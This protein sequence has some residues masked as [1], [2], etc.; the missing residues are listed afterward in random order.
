MQRDGFG[1]A[2]LGELAAL[3]LLFFAAWM[4][5][6]YLTAPVRPDSVLALW[7]QMRA[8]LYLRTAVWTLHPLLAALL[9]LPALL[10]LALRRKQSA[11][12][13]GCLLALGCLA[14][15]LDGKEAL[16]LAGGLL[17]LG[18]TFAGAQARGQSW[19]IVLTTLSLLG[20]YLCFI[21]LI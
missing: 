9:A 5:G 19:Q 4:L 18:G 13:L 6:V 7:R 14:L 12:L 15:L 10:H 17:A 1:P 2:A 16:A 20:C 3:L 8:P 11:W 21:L